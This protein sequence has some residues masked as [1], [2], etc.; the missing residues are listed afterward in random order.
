MTAPLVR[1]A[2]IRRWKI[3]TSTTTGMVTITAAAEI[4]PLPGMP[5]VD[6][7]PVL[8]GHYLRAKLD[9]YYSLRSATAPSPRSGTDPLASSL[10]DPAT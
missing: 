7:E 10:S 1:P 6:F 3:K 9:K 4:A 2:T 5:A 8:A